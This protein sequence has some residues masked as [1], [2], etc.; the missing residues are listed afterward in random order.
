MAN[1]R[2]TSRPALALAFAWALLVVV[3]VHALHFPGSVP[4]FAEASRG[5]ELLDTHPAAS[6]A[7]LYRRLEGYGEAGR[8]NYRFRNLTV[9]VL[10]P[11]SLLPFLLLLMLHAL[12]RLRGRRVPRALLLS[13]PVAYLV[14]DLA[15][16]LAVVALV[17]SFPE[18]LPLLAAA[19]PV[20]TVVKRAALVLALVVPLA[21]FSL[22]M[23]RAEVRPR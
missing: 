16:N 10:L 8:E 6:E 18:R 20:L 12:R 19:L 21:V 7:D 4:D 15:E 9:D 11:V 22:S 3:A 1:P 17:A 2:W 23:I 14:F 5:G 13:L